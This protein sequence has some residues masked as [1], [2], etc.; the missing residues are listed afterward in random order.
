MDWDPGQYALFTSHRLRPALDLLARVD[1]PGPRLVADLGCGNGAVLPALARRWPDAE[2][3]GVDSSPD[4]LAAA[5]EQPARATLVEADAARWR[6]D[7]PVDVIFSNAALHW[8]DHHDRLLPRLMGLLA[9]GGVL[10]IQMPDNFGQPS[11]TLLAEIAAEIKDGAAWRDRAAGVPRRHPVL[12]PADYLAILRPVADDIAVWQTT[13][14]QELTGTDPVLDWT[15]GSCL[16]P[17]LRAL[18]PDQR[19]A[20]TDRYAAR[21]RAAYPADADGRVVFPFQRLFLT[22]RRAD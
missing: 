4:M 1:H 16:R 21:L 11:H 15:R 22:A 19:A 18:Q 8:L 14:H 5:A 12:P 10:A 9:P 3:I 13:Y 6:P 20:F 17:V 7:R 2:L